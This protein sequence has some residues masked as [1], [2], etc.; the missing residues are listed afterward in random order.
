MSPSYRHWHSPVIYE[1]AGVHGPDFYKWR[2]GKM[3]LETATARRLEKFLKDKTP[4]PR[5]QA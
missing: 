3:R 1:E 4:L 5:H 2:S